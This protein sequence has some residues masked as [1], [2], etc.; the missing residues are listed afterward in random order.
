MHVTNSLDNES[1]CS[2]NVLIMFM[3]LMFIGFLG[4]A[5]YPV[6]SSIFNLISFGVAGLAFILALNMR[7]RF[8]FG[9]L[10]LPLVPCIFFT[11]M[12]ALFGIR[13]V[14]TSE[15]PATTV[16]KI[17]C[18]LFLLW[19]A[20]CSLYMFNKFPEQADR[21]TSRERRRQRE[22][23]RQR[24]RGGRELGDSAVDISLEKADP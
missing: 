14:V 5:L 22:Q 7:A 11:S 21:L 20:A 1:K 23:Q 4:V 13:H 15:G 8:W 2:P 10:I 6:S 17:A 16:I 24:L 9:V 12:T 18:P 3:W 19:V